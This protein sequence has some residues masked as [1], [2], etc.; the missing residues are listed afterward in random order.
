MLKILSTL[1]MILATTAC[2]NTGMSKDLLNKDLLKEAQPLYQ[3]C[4]EDYKK[5][6]SDEDA[7]KA[8]TEKLKSGYEKMTNS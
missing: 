5:T 3:T 2:A 1:I 8:C 4:L 6:M 7:R